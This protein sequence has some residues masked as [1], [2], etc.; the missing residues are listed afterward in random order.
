MSGVCPPSREQVVTRKR[1][2]QASDGINLC[3]PSDSGTQSIS[4][5]LLTGCSTALGAASVLALQVWKGICWLWGEIQADKANITTLQAQVAAILTQIGAA[6]VGTP[7]LT[8]G[9]AIGVDGTAELV[10]GSTDIQ[11]VVKVTTG[12]APVGG[13]GNW[14]T[15]NFGTPFAATIYPLFGISVGSASDIFCQS[16][17]PSGPVSALTF[18]TFSPT[19]NIGP[20]S[21]I[22]VAYRM[23][24]TS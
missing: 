17:D 10:A 14:F 19:N 7:T 15:L 2:Q 24:F 12:S 23:G 13:G 1:F 16:S 18:Y 22:F 6:H 21:V 9:F 4:A 5:G 20:A 3:L 8:P 11:G